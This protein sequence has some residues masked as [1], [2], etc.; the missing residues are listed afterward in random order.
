MANINRY[1]YYHY[2]YFITYGTPRTPNFRYVY[3]CQK[4]DT[5]KKWFKK[6][7]GKTYTGH[8]ENGFRL[9]KNW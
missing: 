2:R 9:H 4:L 5:A 8:L 3:G 7:T 1:N 6:L